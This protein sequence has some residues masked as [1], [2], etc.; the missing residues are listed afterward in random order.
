MLAGKKFKGALDT[1]TGREVLDCTIEFSK[2]RGNPGAELG[3]P[4]LREQRFDVHCLGRRQGAR[5]RR[6]ALILSFRDT[7]A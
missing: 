5:R 7:G 6:H 2:L 1:L 4:Q 3:R